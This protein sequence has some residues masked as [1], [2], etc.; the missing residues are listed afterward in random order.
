[1]GFGQKW[2]NFEVGI[3]QLFMSLMISACG[4][5]PLGIILSSNDALTKNCLF[6]SH[7]EFVFCVLFLFR[8]PLGGLK[9]VPGDV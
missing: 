7:H 6:N 3:F 4:K 8:G 1:M 5:T 2:P 9:S